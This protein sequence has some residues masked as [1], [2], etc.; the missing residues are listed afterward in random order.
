MVDENGW[1]NELKREL[2]QIRFLYQLDDWDLVKS[3]A[4]SLCDQTWAALM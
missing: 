3:I 2:K 4:K 1:T